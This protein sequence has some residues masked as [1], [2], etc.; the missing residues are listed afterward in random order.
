MVQDHVH[1]S[2]ESLEY[3]HSQDK[4]VCLVYFACNLIVI[5]LLLLHLILATILKSFYKNREEELS[6]ENKRRATDARIFV[7]EAI[8]VDGDDLSER[9]LGQESSRFSDDADPIEETPVISNF[10][11]NLGLSRQDG[12]LPNTSELDAGAK[13][14]HLNS[15]SSRAIKRFEDKL[16]LKA[17][18]DQSNSGSSR[19]VSVNNAETSKKKKN[20]RNNVHPLAG[21][22]KENEKEFMGSDLDEIC[23]LRN[24]Y[25][26]QPQAIFQAMMLECEAKKISMKVL[27]EAP[28]EES[29]EF[30]D[31]KAFQKCYHILKIKSMTQK[32]IFGIAYWWPAM[33][34]EHVVILLNCGYLLT[35]S[36]SMTREKRIT[37]FYLNAILTGY[38]LLCSALRLYLIK[39]ASKSIGRE[40]FIFL[41]ICIG[42]VSAAELT[43]GRIATHELMPASFLIFMI[44]RV[45]LKAYC[46]SLST[47]LK[48][49]LA[50]VR[51]TMVEILYFVV[52]VMVIILL[53]TFV[54]MTLFGEDTLSSNDLLQNRIL[55]AANFSS[56]GNGLFTV[57]MVLTLE[58]WVPTF[59]EYRKKFNDAFVTIYFVCLTFIVAI[60][61]FKFLLSLII[62]NFMEMSVRMEKMKRFK[63]TTLIKDLTVD[64]QIYGNLE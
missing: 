11:S 24:E 15:G 55:R 41:D 25:S 9:D 37:I 56:F 3:W 45:I 32:V 48:E 18:S 60:V 40:Y 50:Q 49:L 22:H 54:G 59:F 5:N 16:A 21:G 52:I 23:N 38:M 27:K 1:G 42:L 47:S 30:F 58:N 19:K 36:T 39:A 46:T 31:F 29:D 4:T 62:N 6:K 12:L 53:F 17:K 33:L 61:M 35:I 14:G 44:V 34:L 63:E 26:K 43:I 64:D 8:V 10:Q 20:K 28:V 2:L 51:K 57:F 13:L 7:Y